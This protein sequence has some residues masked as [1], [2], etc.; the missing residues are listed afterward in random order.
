MP[1]PP[2]LSTILPSFPI[3]HKHPFKSQVNSLPVLCIYFY[4]LNIN[5][6]THIRHQHFNLI[7]IS[8]FKYIENYFIVSMGS[9]RLIHAVGT[10]QGSLARD[11]YDKL[12][13]AQSFILWVLPR[14]ITGCSQVFTTVNNAACV[15]DC[16][17]PDFLLAMQ[18]EINCGFETPQII[19]F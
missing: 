4:I 8:C 10:C 5:M 15:P 7:S 14:D 17:C 2:S 13:S 3:R 11:F 12:Q 19:C 1:L 16:T 9:V 6:Y 18:Q